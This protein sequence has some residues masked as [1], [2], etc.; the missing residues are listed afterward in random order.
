[1]R[2]SSSE[3]EARSSLSYSR[4]VVQPAGDLSAMRISLF[5]LDN[6]VMIE[7][8]ILADDESLTDKRFCNFV[9]SLNIS[10]LK[11]N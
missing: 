4:T 3:S 9:K 1:M 5:L 10:E 6:L 11:L 7:E 2:F 8:T